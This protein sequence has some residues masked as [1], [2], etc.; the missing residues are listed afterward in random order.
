MRNPI[1]VLKSLSEKSQDKT[2]KYQRLYRNL[3]NP[4]FYLLAY[5]NIYANK[6][7][8]TPGVDGMTIDGISMTRI[9]RIIETLRNQS[10]QPKPA[11]REYIKKKTGNKKRPLGISSADDKLVQEVVR[12]I[13]ESIFEGNFSEKSHGFRP[14][15][16]CHTALTQIRNTFTGTKW[17]IEGDI[18]ACFDSFDHGVLIRILRK[19]IDDELFLNLIRKFL[20]VG[21]MEQWTYNETYFGIPQ[22][23]GCSPILAN[24][25]LNELD[26]FMNELKDKFDIGD[27]NRRKVSYEYESARG[28]AKRLKKKYA[29]DWNEVSEEERKRRAEEIKAIKDIYTKMPRYEARDG[30]FKKIQ[31]TRYCDDF[32]IGVI[33]SKEDAEAIKA[34]VKEFLAN[35]LNLTLSDEKT[36]ITHTSECAEFL[37][38]RIT[39]SRNEGIKRRKDGR[40]TRPYSAVVKL[41]V[42]KENWIKKLLE[43]EAIKIVSDENGNEKWKATHS[44]KVLNKTD[45]E[46]LS[47]YNAKVRGLFNYYCI[48]DNAY[49]IGK[50]GR[51][52]KYSMMKTFAFK[53]K[54]KVSKIKKK[55]VINGDFTVSYVTKQGVK[56]SV[57][58]NQGYGKRDTSLAGQIEILPQYKRYDK[59][60]SLSRKLKTKTCE[61]CRSYCTEIEIHQVKKLKNLKGEHE[62]ERLMLKARRKTLAVCPK[63]H[64]EIHSCDEER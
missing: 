30:N 23:S 62:W 35:E 19:R 56:N 50:F 28:K 20:K 57:F 17:F 3:Y 4:E 36:K 13:L 31:Y 21:Y 8:M 29:K 24:I 49:V 11:R 42:P 58:Y 44:G 2:Y 7:S 10:Y 25:Y 61:L 63:C 22:G 18:K 38:Y 55:Y 14:N 6:G 47:D 45:I 26:E 1:N 5:Q 54:T 37:G 60:N 15:K 52:M 43:Y 9:N 40:K 48:A 12:M 39:V 51:A 41:Y 33:G 34:K 32:L 64:S 59:P 16:S 46:I 53:Y 27:S